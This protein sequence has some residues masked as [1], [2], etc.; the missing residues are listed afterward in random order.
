MERLDIR[1]FGRASVSVGGVP[2]KFA[3]RQA[4]LAMLA[5]VLLERGQPISRDVLAFKLFPEADEATA[6]A[7]LRRYLYLANKALPECEREPWLVV[8]ADSVRWNAASDAF[9]DV[10]AFERFAAMPE[11]HARAIDLYAG[12]LL[13]DIYEDWV[14]AERER[15]RTR[16]LTIL[17]E[18]LE[19]HRER[20]DF[21]AA[22]A[23]ATRLLVTDPWREDTLRA[24]LTVRYESGDTS[25]AL[26]EYERFSRRL[27]DELGVAPMAETVALRASIVRDE[28]V[29]GAFARRSTPADGAPARRTP[30][31][32]FVGRQRELGVL[33]A[34]WGRAARGSG[35]FV[36][37]SGEPGVGKTRLAEE[38][39]RKAQAEGGRVAVGTTAAPE[40]MPYQ[41]IVEALRSS[42]P[43]L[44][45]RPLVP[46]RRSALARVLPE[47]RDADAPEI[48]ATDVG[49]ERETAR[50]YDAF[51][52][53]IRTLA[54]PRPL[55][56]C[57]EDLHWAGPASIEALG[58][59]VRELAR[60]PVLVVATTRDDEV[61][62]DH[63]LAT[64]LRSLRVS[65]NVDE[66]VLDRLGES[67]VFDLVERV[68]GLREREGVLARDLYAHS[69]GNALFLNEAIGGVLERGDAEISA[70]SIVALLDARIARLGP[71][72]RAV[73]EIAAVVGLGCTV[74]LVRDAANLP[75]AAI[76]DGFDELLDRRIVREAGARAGYDYAFT[77][78]LVATSLY[79]AMEPTFR[80][81]R[82]SR[83]ARLLEA[84]YRTDDSTPA[85]EIARHFERAGESARSATW[86]LTAAESAAAVYA[87]GDAI[88]SATRALAQADT[89]TAKRRA[90]DIR[91]RA[92]ARRGDRDGQRV[93]IDALEALAG[94]DLQSRFDVLARR[95]SLA[96]SLGH[97]GDE[98][99]AV[100]EMERLA[101]RLDD[102]ARARALTERATHAGLRSRPSDGLEP[103]RAALAIYER[104]GSVRGQLDCLALLV[105]FSANVGDFA[106][107]RG[108]LATMRERAASVHDRVVEARALAVA[109]TAALLR[110]EY[111]ECFDLTVLALGLHV[112]TNDREGEAGARGRLAVTAAWLCDFET[113]LREFDL[114]LAAYE[115]IGNTRG[116]AV[117]HTNRT[118]MLM[119]L[120]LF[121]DAL[122]SIERSNALFAIANERRTIVANKVN[123]SFVR[124][125]RGDATR[126]KALADEALG[127]AREI[128]FPLFEAAALANV[129]NAERALGDLDAAIEHMEAGIAIRRPLQESRDFADDLADLTLAYA[130][131]R[132]DLDALAAAEE[133]HAIGLQ[134]FDGALWPHYPRYALA[135]GFRRG[136]ALER[137]RESADRARAE[138]AAF[139]E[140]ISDDRARAA[141]LAVPINARIASAI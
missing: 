9:V 51:A 105:D 55:V 109:A 31:L 79:D 113:A 69:E 42:L 50:L 74:A 112:T 125:Q 128:G 49:P 37:L 52:H 24:L 58:S 75:A 138:L 40:S 65:G 121:D 48:A 7:E 132:R 6:L 87:Y 33:H 56:L 116:L 35:T 84:S 103:A 21:G 66:L 133:L 15:L 140:G 81:Q 127:I 19:R 25:G 134:S 137:A 23:T 61:A 4:T 131:A 14:L 136:G 92:R 101:E 5:L 60:V 88:D 43:L 141:F 3:K 27:R 44:T 53:A 13:E 41:A 39:A 114:A 123:E 104:S 72:A 86:Y 20:R 8:D 107:S 63:P 96:R 36:V 45:A 91:E 90:L 34:A 38:L 89:T 102:D 1:L 11:T 62:P 16:Y 126:A 115:A 85:R 119:R 29:P 118:V 68:P 82:H 106:A 77:H 135:E 12:D 78:H 83:I 108:Y 10:V 64:L 110:Q 111:R 122:V 99:D 59:I 124:L 95:V 17:D 47:L 46:A 76:A 100:A 28:S 129:G 22:I 67:D 93:D 120:G 73:A 26:A 2:V 98:G 70:T 54:S 30:V 94:D 97:S 18:S 130:A 57:L 80:A 139:A 117:T 32:P 71:H